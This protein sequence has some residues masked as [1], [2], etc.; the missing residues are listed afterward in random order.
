MARELRH[1]PAE[2]EG[3]IAAGKWLSE[4]VRKD[5]GTQVAL[6]KAVDQDGVSKKFSRIATGK[7]RLD[8]S[9]AELIAPHL[10]S[11]EGSIDRL[12]AAYDNEFEKALHEL[13]HLDRDEVDPKVIH[14]RVPGKI[15]IDIPVGELTAKELI[16]LSTSLLPKP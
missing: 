9:F 11:A 15:E 4:L 10:P 7:Y 8:R 13:E 5:V 1:N 14:I 6:E 3:L 16:D 12:M 2:Y